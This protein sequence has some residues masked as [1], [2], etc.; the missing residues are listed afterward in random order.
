VTGV[1]TCALP[2]YVKLMMVLA[3]GI[4][5]ALCG[6]AGVLFAPVYYI[7][8]AVGVPFTARAFILAVLGGMGNI[9]GA[10]VAGLVLGVAESLGV[11]I[12]GQAWREFAGLLVFILVLVFKPSGLLGTRTD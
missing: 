5:V 7:F 6:A 11:V 2:I 12:A 4:A 9:I 8:P 3:F 10:I 1:Q